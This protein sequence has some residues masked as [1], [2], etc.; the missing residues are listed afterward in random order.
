MRPHFISLVTMGLFSW[1]FGSCSPKVA[2][3]IV[4][5]SE[6]TVGME[7]DGFVDL[8]FSLSSY[9]RLVDGI[10]VCVA[11]GLHKG[12]E[13]S[14]KFRLPSAWKQGTLGD[15]GITTYQSTVTIESL[16]TTSD[17]FVTTLGGLYGGALRPTKMAQA[18]TFTAIS[19]G[20]VPSQLEKGPTKIKLFFEP[21]EETDDAYDRYYAEHYLNIDLAAKWVEFHEKDEGYRDAVLRALSNTK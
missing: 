19:L 5:L 14:F 16:G 4:S 1:L 6:I 18:V 13:V 10:Q 20:G 11:R 9:E 12:S 21:T 15:T 17:H 3:P 2:A 7:A 8:G